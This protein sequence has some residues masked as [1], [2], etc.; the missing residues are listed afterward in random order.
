MSATNSKLLNETKNFHNCKVICQQEERNKS[1]AIVCYL[2]VHICTFVF[3][4]TKCYVQANLI[5]L[6]IVNPPHAAIPFKLA[7]SQCLRTE[8]MKYALV[9]IVQGKKSTKPKFTTYSRTVE[10]VT[11][12]RDL[13]TFETLK[14]YVQWKNAHRYLVYNRLSMSTT[15]Q[16]GASPNV[17]CTLCLCFSSL[18]SLASLHF[19]K[20]TGAVLQ[21]HTHTHTYL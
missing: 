21:T 5:T 14:I 17:I 11:P 3:N 15:S 8:C 16:G 20:M 13:K 7:V 1:L 18:S 19:P 12:R 10:F 6:S 4:S 9:K 2:M